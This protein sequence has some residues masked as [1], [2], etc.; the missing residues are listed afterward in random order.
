MFSEI[1]TKTGLVLGRLK[2]LSGQEF[3]NPE[4][5]YRPLTSEL[6]ILLFRLNKQRLLKDSL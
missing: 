3:S 4:Q 6:C 5:V 2:F 1:G